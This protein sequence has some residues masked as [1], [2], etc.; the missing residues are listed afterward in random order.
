[1]KDSGV[2]APRVLKLGIRF[3]LQP[4][5]LWYVLDRWPGEFQAGGGHIG[6]PT[7]QRFYKHRKGNWKLPLIQIII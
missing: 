2:T 6:A 7:R 4:L 1:M 5:Y 3:G